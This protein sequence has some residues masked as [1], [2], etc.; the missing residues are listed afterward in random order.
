LIQ[1]DHPSPEQFASVSHKTTQRRIHEM[2]CTQFAGARGFIRRKDLISQRSQVQ[3][4][5]HGQMHKPGLCV[6]GLVRGLG[7]GP[8]QPGVTCHSSGTG[9]N[10]MS[11]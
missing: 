8:N 11:S 1:V 9:G 10:K 6:C 5:R 2:H 4:F 3:G 7:C